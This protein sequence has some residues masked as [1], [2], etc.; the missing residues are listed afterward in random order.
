[1]SDPQNVQLSCADE[2]AYRTR[3]TAEKSTYRDCVEVH[4]LPDA[5]HYWSNRYMRPKLEAFGFGSPDDMF[6][7]YLLEQCQSRQ[8]DAKRFLSIG[9]GN[10]DL[11]IGLGTHLRAA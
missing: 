4:G 10:C 3:L 2:T 7:K 11:E 5:F 1:M 8:N 9:S 6:R